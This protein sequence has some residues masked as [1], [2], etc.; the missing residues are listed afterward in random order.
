MFKEFLGLLLLHLLSL[1]NGLVSV[2]SRSSGAFVISWSDFAL[3]V[4]VWF[5]AQIQ[6]LVLRPLQEH[7]TAMVGDVVGESQVSQV[8]F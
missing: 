6:L 7:V 3:F 8:G 5:S 2:V 1:A 4:S